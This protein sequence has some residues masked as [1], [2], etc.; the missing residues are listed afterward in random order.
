MYY[1]SAKKKKASSTSPHTKQQLQQQQQPTNAKATAIEFNWAA[2]TFSNIRN[3]CIYVAVKYVSYAIL[4]YPRRIDTY[5]KICA[6]RIESERETQ[7]EKKT[8]KTLPI[9]RG[10]CRASVNSMSNKSNLTIH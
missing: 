10:E 7:T 3:L 2:V 6:H 9:A 1:Y 5:S 8:T 4:K